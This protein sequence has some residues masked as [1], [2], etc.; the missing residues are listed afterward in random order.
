MSDNII[1]FKKMEEKPKSTK[2]N[3][4]ENKP[5]L[6]FTNEMRDRLKHKARTKYGY[7]PTNWYYASRISK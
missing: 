6:R 4:F 2:S 3:D 5:K 1:P 7:E